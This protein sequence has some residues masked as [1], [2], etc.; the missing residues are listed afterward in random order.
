M[1]LL[2]KFS[3]LEL[4]SQERLSGVVSAVH[5]VNLGQ[6]VGT[7]EQLLDGTGR[8][9]LL[10]GSIAL[11]LLIED[12]EKRSDR[13]PKRKKKIKFKKEYPRMIQPM[14]QSVMH[15]QPDIRVVS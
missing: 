8:S 6:V 13:D 4:G 5:L 3:A 15:Y 14:M 12:L 1:L 9:E 11:L 10:G 2:S 7:R